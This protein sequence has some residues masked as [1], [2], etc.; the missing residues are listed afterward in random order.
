MLSHRRDLQR[1]PTTLRG[2]WSI[3]RPFSHS[4]L[5]RTPLP[6]CETPAYID[7]DS[8]ALAKP[9]S[10]SAPLLQMA[11]PSAPDHTLTGSRYLP[12]SRAVQ[13]QHPLQPHPATKTMMT[14][15]KLHRLD[16][17]LLQPT[18]LKRP[19]HLPAMLPLWCP[20]LVC[21]VLF[22]QR[23]C[24]DWTKTLLSYITYVF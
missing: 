23:S 13:I 20:G 3:Q 24:S 6:I 1:D 4:S 10:P 9:L 15:R 8:N 22:W 21:S 18:P 12:H 2:R 11:R 16:L 17:P 7:I 14:A 19:P 5:V